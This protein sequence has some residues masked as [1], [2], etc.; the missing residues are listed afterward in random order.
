MFKENLN[1]RILSRVN[2]NFG[3]YFVFTLREI[4]TNRVVLRK[5]SVII[6]IYYAYEYKM[7]VLHIYINKKF[8]NKRK[9]TCSFFQTFLF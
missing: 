9:Y 7:Y 5:S 3:R 4:E 8:R 1:R 2:N 6:I